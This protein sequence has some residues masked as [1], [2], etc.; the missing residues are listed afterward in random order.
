[1]ARA[2]IYKSEVV[3]AR[4]NL[5]AMG[6]TRRSMPSVVNWATP[7]PKAR[8]TATWAK[9]RKRKVVAPALRSRSAKPFRICR[10]GWLSAHQEADGRLAALTDKHKAEIAALNDAMAALRNES[11]SFVGD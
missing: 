7:A 6:A 2:G 3:R 1:M 10:P 4:N 8:F 9:S 11:E 5:L